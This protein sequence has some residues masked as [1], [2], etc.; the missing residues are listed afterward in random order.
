MKKSRTQL[1]TE[2]VTEILPSLYVIDYKLV[3][4]TPQGS[5]RIHRSFRKIR[6]S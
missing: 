6:S 1:G 5:V 3:V 2:W 4:S